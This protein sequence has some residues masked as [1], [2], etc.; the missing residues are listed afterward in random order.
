MAK[1]CALQNSVCFASLDVPEACA[2]CGNL[3]EDTKMRME[4]L[5]FES[6]EAVAKVLTFGA[7]KY[8]DYGWKDQENAECENI[9]ALLRHLSAHLKGERIDAESGLSHL[10]HAAARALFLVYFEVKKNG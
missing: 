6:L 3:I 2:T 1:K 5:P 4:L 10:S 8:S 9:G 7:V